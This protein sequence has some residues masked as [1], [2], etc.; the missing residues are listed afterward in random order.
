MG[1]NCYFH[2]YILWLVANDVDLSSLYALALCNIYWSL[3]VFYLQQY[4]SLL[5]G[6][7]V[8]FAQLC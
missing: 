8:Q 6:V 5:F 3:T 2:D 7:Q 4:Y 1:L